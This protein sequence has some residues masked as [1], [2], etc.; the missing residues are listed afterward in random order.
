MK[1]LYSLCWADTDKLMLGERMR[2][3][4]LAVTIGIMHI[5]PCNV[6]AITRL[7]AYAPLE[8]RPQPLDREI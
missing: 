8:F 4:I 6:V 7:D 1:A 2:L 3:D 5:D